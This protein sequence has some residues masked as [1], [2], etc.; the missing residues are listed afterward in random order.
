VK[1]DHSA[2]PCCRA[3]I[4]F[5]ISWSL[6]LLLLLPA[7]QVLFV[8]FRVAISVVTV[9]ALIVLVKSLQ[10]WRHVLALPVWLLL[11]FT[12]YATWAYPIW[13]QADWE[14]AKHEK[15]RQEVQ[16]NEVQR[17]TVTEQCALS[18][19]EIGTHENT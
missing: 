10:A 18:Q 9:L 15:Q 19:R 11:A 6:F 1:S 3:A 4:L 16:R 14:R 7:V 8:G 17:N 12:L 5:P 13:T 2:T